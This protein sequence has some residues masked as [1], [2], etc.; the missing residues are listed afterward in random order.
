MRIKID[1]FR[2]NMFLILIF[3]KVKDPSN[4]DIINIFKTSGFITEYFFYLFG[5]LWFIGDYGIN[6]FK[7]RILF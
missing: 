6:K 3:N 5:I 1:K 4:I 7:E 2:L